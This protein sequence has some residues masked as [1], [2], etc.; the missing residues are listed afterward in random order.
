M[1][2]QSPVWTSSFR[3][4]IGAS[5]VTVSIQVKE[6]GLGLSFSVR[7]SLCRKYGFGQY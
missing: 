1:C 6:P 4:G 3:Y 2:G 7:K 5:M